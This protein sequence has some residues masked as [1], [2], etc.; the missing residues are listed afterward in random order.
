[1]LYSTLSSGNFTIPRINAFDE[2]ELTALFTVTSTFASWTQRRTF[3]DAL[4]LPFLN[5]KTEQPIA[6]ILPKRRSG[7]GEDKF[8][9]HLHLRGDAADAAEERE[10]VFEVRGQ[11]AFKLSTHMFH[12]KTG[13]CVM[14][15]RFEK[16][17]IFAGYVV[18]FRR[19]EWEVI[20]AEGMD[21]LLASVITVLLAMILYKNSK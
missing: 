6:T 1:M 12:R 20:A 17:S 13:K 16:R 9:V 18:L 5:R 4:G 10:P 3:L 19:P 8:D 15:V 2:V 11:D 21:V 7:T 14:S